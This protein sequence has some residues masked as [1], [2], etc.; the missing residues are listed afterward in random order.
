D[1]QDCHDEIQSVAR[2][3]NHYEPVPSIT[4]GVSATS[5]HDPEID[6]TIT[7]TK[8]PPTPHIQEESIDAQ[9]SS[10]KRAPKPR[11]PLHTSAARNTELKTTS[12]LPIPEETF[13]E[14]LDVD[15]SDEE[16]SYTKIAPTP[17]ITESTI[18]APLS[19][20]KR[21]P[22][23]RLPV[24][25]IDHRSTELKTASTLPLPEETFAEQ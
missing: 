1:S 12:T 24:D 17:L 11:V 19:S 6:Q 14:Q 20:S 7:P 2:L 8:I 25:T 16:G 9:L 13:D 21:T 4:E 5:E 10:T 3:Q 18:A 23:P 15:T 22:K